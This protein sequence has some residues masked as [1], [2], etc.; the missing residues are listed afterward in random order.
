MELLYKSEAGKN[1]IFSLYNQK[2]KG[3]NI[4]YQ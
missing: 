3:L 2:L 4:K 1:E